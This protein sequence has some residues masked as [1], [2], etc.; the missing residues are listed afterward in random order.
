[1]NTVEQ[2]ISQLH[3]GGLVDMHFDLPLGLFWNRTR[4]N[5]IATDF[6]PELEAGDIGLVGV[7]IYVEDKYL[8][9]RALKVALAPAAIDAVAGPPTTETFPPSG[10]AR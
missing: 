4:K 7:A 9:D 3:Q 1:M 5:I 6:L 8:P 10:A 2:R